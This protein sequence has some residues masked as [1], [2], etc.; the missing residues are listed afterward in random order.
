MAAPTLTN[1]TSQATNGSGTAVSIPVPTG[2]TSGAGVL[3]IV[4]TNGSSTITGF[5]TTGL[6]HAPGSPFASPTSQFNVNVLWKR[7]TGADSGSYALTQASAQFWVGGGGLVSNM[8]ASGNPWDTNSGTGTA[9]VSSSSANSLNTSMTTQAADELLINAAGQFNGAAS[10]TQPTGFTKDFVDTT[11]PGVLFFGHLAQATA[12]GTGTLTTVVGV[13]ASQMVDWLGALLPVASGAQTIDA[14]VPVTA[15]ITATAQEVANAAAAVPV[16]AA[17]TATASE[18]AN[19]TT[20]RPT[21]VTIAATAQEVAN[22]TATVSTTATVTAT[23]AVTHPITAAVATTATITAAALE[24]ANAQAS[25]TTT[26]TITAA[27]SV[28]T[29]PVTIDATV[30][31]TATIAAN[32]VAIHPIDTSRPTTVTIAAT[33]TQAANAQAT[34]PTVATIT[35]SATQI[36]RASTN[37]ATLATITAVLST[38]AVSCDTTRPFIGTTVY[39][40]ATTGRPDTGQTD[41]PCG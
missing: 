33:A 2:V 9:R 32:A 10:W 16:T 8:V 36:A 5:G 6:A 15:I 31:V 30:P 25:V 28:G 39:A 35:A 29:A 20:T 34:R 1:I 22:A 19:A 27:L 11:A 41:P 38:G 12:G 37:V 40:L 23:L 3:V 14:T 24:V 7:A 18:I 4:F 26:A 17:I 21:T 13:S